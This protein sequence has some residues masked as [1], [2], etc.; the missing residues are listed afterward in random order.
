VPDKN[1]TNKFE[2]ITPQGY[3][4]GDKPTK[5]KFVKKTECDRCG[6][7]CSASTPSL[8]KEDIPL[9]RSSILSFDNTFTIREGELF[10]VK[11]EE[12]PYRAFMELLKVRPKEGSEECIFYQA[13]EGC[14]IYDNRPTQCAAFACWELRDEMTGLQKNALHRKDLFGDIELMAGIIDRH[15]ERCSYDKLGDAVTK[16]TGG[17]EVAA[18]EIVDMLQYDNFIRSYVTERFNIPESSLD[19]VFG[20][21]MAGRIMDFGVKVEK[22]GDEYILSPVNNKEGK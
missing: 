7:C 4:E 21:P 17:D 6:G 15:E 8:L 11:G 2:I 19:L 14:T 22:E 18:E 13:D 20:K 10:A 3:E 5:M 16:A 1:K 12:E 9:F